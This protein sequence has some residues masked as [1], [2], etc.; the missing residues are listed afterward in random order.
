MK[1]KYLILIALNKDNETLS[2][3]LSQI[4]KDTFD[5]GAYSHWR[6]K[7]GLGICVLTEWSSGS[8]Y[9]ALQQ[10]CR[11]SHPGFLAHLA[12]LELADDH[13]SQEG[14]RLLAWAQQGSAQSQISQ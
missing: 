1:R 8:M 10:H 14:S 6:D 7:T 5:A 13:A 3:K 9:Q 11:K 4:C 2:L 12:V